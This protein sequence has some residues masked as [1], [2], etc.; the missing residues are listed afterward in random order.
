MGEVLIGIGNGC[1]VKVAANDDAMIGKTVDEGADA[2]GL[3]PSV[4][5]GFA[6]LAQEQV[7]AVLDG[8][9]TGLLYGIG[10][11]V[12]LL[13]AQMVAFQVIVDEEK[14][15]AVASYPASYAVIAAGGIVDVYG[16]AQEG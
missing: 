8:F 11:I 1:L 9:S 5:G 3:C 12:F 4:C 15:V 10:V 13:R 14:A 2:V 6:Q 16:V 7:R